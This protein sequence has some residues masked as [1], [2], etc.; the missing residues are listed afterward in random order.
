MDAGGFTYI[1]GP[2]LS[3][4]LGRSLGLDLLGRR[5]CSMNCV[6]CES[7]RLETLTLTRAPYVP[8]SE[9][10]AELERW[11]EGRRLRGEPLPDVATLGGLG[12]P[13]L[14]SDMPEIIRG[15]RRILPGVPVA[16]LTNASLMT[17][18][19][20]RAELRLADAVLPS[21][22]ALAPEEFRAVNRAHPGL[23]PNAIADGILEFRKG[24]EGRL[25]LEILLVA[26]VNDSS[27]NL[28][29]LAEYCKR[30]QPDRVDVVTLSRPGTEAGAR[31]VDAQTL[32]LWRERLGVFA[33]PAQAGLARAAEKGHKQPGGMRPE[34]LSVDELG[35][36]ILA[37]L[38]RRP[39]TA[40]QLAAALLAPEETV[41]GALAL[42]A[43]KGQAE[44]VSGSGPGTPIFYQ[45]RS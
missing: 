43:A 10:L 36:R 11:E 37:S 29:L 25:Y 4:R 27:R 8:A 23:D 34:E 3:G 15:I 2:V 45:A 21:L 44:A 32:A 16:V 9:L 41:R 38:S 28:E 17:D 39:Q 5:V 13:T 42:L 14:N 12:E 1:F 26:G 22:D 6:Y 31:A 18:A 33:R 7:G 20:V 24:Y 40:A 35:A 30:L 19:Q